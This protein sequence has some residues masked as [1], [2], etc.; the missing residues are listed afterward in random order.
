[1]LYANDEFFADAHNLIEPRPAGARPGGLRDPRQGVRRLGDP[2][3]PGARRGLRHH[4][5]G[6]ARDR[7]AGSTSTPRTSG[8]TTRRLARSTGPRCSATPR[9]PRC[10]RAAWTPLAGQT[11]LGG[12]RAN[13]VPVTAPDR[14]VTHVRLTIHPDGGVARLRVFGEVVPDPRRLGGRVDLAA[15]CR[16]R[17]GGGVQQHVLLRSRPTRSRRGGPR[18]CR[19]AGRP[20]AAATTGT[21]GWWSGWRRRA[22]CTTP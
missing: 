3:A 12:D 10:W 14:L 6:R 21:T 4:P 19:T 17:A 11:E 22:C 8:A 18:S 15:T 2:A 9:R 20:R 7:R 1:M 5:A 16:R 13:L